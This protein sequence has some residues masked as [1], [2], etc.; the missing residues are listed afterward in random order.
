MI[1]TDLTAA[2]V[3]FAGDIRNEDFLNALLPAAPFKIRG[4]VFSASNPPCGISEYAVFVKER[5][6][7]LLVDLCGAAQGEITAAATELVNSGA[8]VKF[9]S[10]DIEVL[11]T[12]KSRFCEADFL[13]RSEF[14]D[15]TV[16]PALLINGFS[17]DVYYDKLTL[18]RVRDLHGLGIKTF[19]HGVK[20]ADV[21][22]LLAFYGADGIITDNPRVFKV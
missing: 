19:C 12:L 21:A 16:V 17:A 1:N 2:P 9:I 22:A 14:F 13:L 11:K 8:S 5:G 4:V 18:E 3:Y 10:D 7:T 15:V 6:L 20:E